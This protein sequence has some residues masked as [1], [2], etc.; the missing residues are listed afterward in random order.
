LRVYLRDP[1]RPGARAGGGSRHRAAGG[2]RGL[3]A[4]RCL[5]ARAVGRTR[6]R[7]RGRSA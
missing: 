5:P 2:A 3:P 4:G 1:G 7:V 6:R